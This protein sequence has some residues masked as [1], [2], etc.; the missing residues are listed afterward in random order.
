MADE[1]NITGTVDIVPEIPTR[2]KLY[3]EPEY[4]FSD[5]EVYNDT[6]WNNQSPPAITAERLNHIEYGI[7]VL[8]D[9]L[10][11]SDSNQ[12]V[13]ADYNAI[14]DSIRSLVEN[15][16]NVMTDLRA[17]SDAIDVNLAKERVDR[18]TEDTNIRNYIGIIKNGY[19]TVVGQIDDEISK[20][21]GNLEDSIKKLGDTTQSNLK[22]LEESLESTSTDLGDRI[23]A[24]IEAMGKAD[25][26]L[27]SSIESLGDNFNEFKDTLTLM[28]VHDVGTGK[29]VLISGGSPKMP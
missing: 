1:K 6:K 4:H 2:A 7:S 14:V 25:E 20:L 16:I 11:E 3:S 10:T 23:D 19:E 26:K 8:N 9:Y 27:S 5:R 24:E 15:L 13:A 22:E 18:E 17:Y 21:K 28:E 12:G 29:T